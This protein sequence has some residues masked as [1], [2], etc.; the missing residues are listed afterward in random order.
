MVPSSSSTTE[1]VLSGENPKVSIPGGLN[2]KGVNHGPGGDN[3]KRQSIVLTL[4][5]NVTV[6]HYNR[7][8]IISPC[9]CR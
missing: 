8:D 7:E 3:N 1:T 2:E 9:P 6:L 4:E 5:R